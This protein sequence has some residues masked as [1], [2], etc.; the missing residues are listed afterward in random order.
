[1]PSVRTRRC[2]VGL[3]T[4]ADQGGGRA[5][6]VTRRQALNLVT[7]TVDKL[8]GGQGRAGREGRARLPAA[9]DARGCGRIRSRAGKHAPRS[10]PR[11]KR[12]HAKQSHMAGVEAFEPLDGLLDAARSGSARDLRY[13]LEED[14]DSDLDLL[15]DEVG[16]NA[17]HICCMNGHIESAKLLLYAGASIDHRTLDGST[18][19]Y[20]CCMFDMAECAAFLLAK[21]AGVNV[22]SDNGWTPLL[23]SCHEGHY[24]CARLCVAYGADVEHANGEGS[25]PLITACTRGRL[26]CAKLCLLAGASVDRADAIGA[27]ALTMACAFGRVSCAKL[28]LMAGADAT[29]RA[30]GATAVEWAMHH[31]QVA[32]VALLNGPRPHRAFVASPG[33]TAWADNLLPPFGKAGLD[34]FDAAD[35]ELALERAARCGALPNELARLKEQGARAAAADGIKRSRWCSPGACW[36]CVALLLALPHLLVRTWATALVPLPPWAPAALRVDVVTDGAIRDVAEARK[37]LLDAT[38]SRSRFSIPW[39]SQSPP[40]APPLSPPHWHPCSWP[41]VASLCA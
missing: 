30:G 31:Q 9:S 22:S 2:A 37:V 24:A 14:A 28:C 29:V 1:M 36:V 26:E 6:S 34:A 19:L 10:P 16:R 18:A 17:L 39:L 23:A 41:W 15:V 5:T 33:P 8:A 4:G 25:T 21:G 35:F 7:D 3:A 32:A 40:P 11:Q 20:I 12:T 13:A 38:T 27:T